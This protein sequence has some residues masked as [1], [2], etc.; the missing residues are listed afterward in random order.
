MAETRLVAVV[1]E[2][3]LVAAVAEQVVAADMNRIE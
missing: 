1:V 3:R 2:T